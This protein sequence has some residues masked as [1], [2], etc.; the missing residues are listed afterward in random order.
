MPNRLAHET[1]PYLLQHRDNPVDWYPWGPEALERARAE[2]RPIMLSVGYS[3]CHWCH[4]MEHESFEDAETARLMNE[5]YVNVKVDRE[6]RPDIDSIYMTA[7]Q[8]MTGHGGWPMTVFLTPEG[9]PFYGGTYFPPEPR[10][11]MPSFRQVLLAV[12]EAYRERRADVD[13]SAAELHALLREGMAARAP[14]GALDAS[15]LDRAFHQLAARFDARLGGFGGAPKFP[16]PMILEFVLRHWKR[17]G[18]PEALRMAEH[19]LRRMAAGGMY[20]QAGGGFHRYSVDARWL[21]PHFEKMLYDNALLARVYLQAWQATGDAEHR[22]VVEEVL[23]YVQREMRS[24]EGGFY[25]AQD[26]DSEGEEGRFYVWTPDEVDG[27]LGP[28][29][30]PLFRAYYD[31]TA[32]G[33]FEGSNI[34][35]VDRSAEEVAAE[36]GV[37]VERLERALAR[38]RET[39]YEA[40]ARRVWPGLDDKVLTAW[41]AM[42]LRTFAEAA[43]VLGSG[44]YLEVANSSADFLLRELRRDRRLLRTWKEGRAKIDAFLEDHAL[45]ADALVSLYEATG[46]VGR[47]AA[48]RELADAML[49][50]FWDEDESVFYDTAVDAE[51]LVVRPRDTFDNATPSGSS[52]AVMALLRLAALTGEPRYGRVAARVLEGMGELMTRVPQ[53]FGNLLAA[54]DFHLATPQEV[55]VVGRAGEPDTEVLLDLLRLRFLPNTVLAL[56]DP[57]APAEAGEQVPLLQ[58]RTLVDGRPAAYVCERYACRRPVT[59]AA[60]LA[61]LLDDTAA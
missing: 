12:M 22:R 35:H 47:V 34:L 57:D 40:R 49:E 23:R 48:A 53:G 59:G 3:A 26:A 18:S 60:E 31:V 2:D 51:A 9:V 20:D 1:S 6:E 8:Q 36:A 54:A 45:L 7:V 16:Q 56:A 11:G 32:A 52:A 61:E 38:G 19:T 43:R 5:L 25:S 42:M 30:G 27:L 46:D 13:R 29:D 39:L 10:H 41:N 33:N 58:G 44:E 14:S 17:T 21:V 37:S 55:V 24:P 15:V 50:R 28:E 4:V